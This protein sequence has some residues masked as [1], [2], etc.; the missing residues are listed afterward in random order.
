MN[1]SRRDWLRHLASLGAAATLTRARAASGAGTQPLGLVIHSYPVRQRD[2]QRRFTGPLAFLQHARSLGAAGCQTMIGD[3]APDELA[4]VREF[5]Q[6]TG[7][8]LEGIVSLPRDR[9]DLGR[10]RSE[11][12]AA[13]DCGARVLRTA[14]LSGRRYETFDSADAFRKFAA[15]GFARLE[16]ARPV[17][18][19]ADMLL[20]VENHKDW[21]VPE[22]IDILGRVKSPAVGVCLD[23]GNSVSLLE[24]PNEVVEQLIP[25]AVTTHFKDVA[26]REYDE[27]FL[28]SEVPLGKGLLD[29][30][31]LVGSLRSKGRPGV[32]LNLE[33]ITR[34]PL[35]V[36]CLTP[37]YWATFADLPGRYLAAQLTLVRRQGW[38]GPLPEVSGLAPEE[39]LR[40]EDRNVQECLDFASTHL[41]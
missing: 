36:P 11:V 1:T 41:T 29:L 32:R 37:K 4:R 35:K 31:R 24:G 21:R 2:P 9:D 20:G 25:F 30:P 5:L 26:V 28:L 3:P 16:L 40:A 7:L 19:E 18:E 33:M 38:K 39:Q 15:D 17:I 6:E 22:L 10:F 27:G 12:K 14:M 34:D 23:F 8:Y 13:R